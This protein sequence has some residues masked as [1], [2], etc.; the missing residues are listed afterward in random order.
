MDELYGHVTAMPLATV[1]GRRANL[2]VVNAYYNDMAVNEV[3]TRKIRNITRELCGA[4]FS[5]STPTVAGQRRFYSIMPDST[6]RGLRWDVATCLQAGEV[7][8]T[9]WDVPRESAG[10]SRGFRGSGC[11]LSCG[12]QDFRSTCR[13]GD[14]ICAGPRNGREIWVPRIPRMEGPPA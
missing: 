4:E 5:R 1:N 2:G 3:S 12:R 10:N 7:N 13:G 14:R 11:G 8:G 9:I 6:R